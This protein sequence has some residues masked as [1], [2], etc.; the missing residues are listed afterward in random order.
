[1]TLPKTACPGC[2][3]TVI[4]ECEECRSPYGSTAY[5]TP[6]SCPNCGH[7]LGTLEWSDLNRIPD[8]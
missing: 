6:I 1:M 7:R 5:I 3:A 8:T 2:K 4:P